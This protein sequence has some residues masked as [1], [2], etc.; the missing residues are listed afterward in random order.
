M[1]TKLQLLLDKLV[2][3]ENVFD[4]IQSAMDTLDTD[5]TD[6]C[7]KVDSITDCE[8]D[9]VDSFTIRNAVDTVVS[10]K[11]KVLHIR[12]E[13]I[14]IFISAGINIEVLTHPQSKG[15]K[16]YQLPN[17]ENIAKALLT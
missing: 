4:E 9:A 12:Q 7:D 11:D 17:Y 5:I 3:I 1:S 14:D 6:L 15:L 8:E 13:I 10:A 16:A 2:E